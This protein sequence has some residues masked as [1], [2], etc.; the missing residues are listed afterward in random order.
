M[1]TTFKKLL[2]LLPS[3][4]NGKLIILFFMMLFGA[5]LELL[6]IGMIP[7]FV[8]IIA[9]PETILEI[10]RLV[11]AWEALDIEDGGD[12][13]VYGSILLIGVFLL[14]NVY[15]ASFKYIQTRFIWRRFA[16]IGTYLFNQYMRAPYKFHLKRNSSELLRNITQETRLIISRLLTPLLKLVMDAVLILGIF[17]ML[18]WVEPIIT[19]G[20]IVLLGGSSALFLK[21]IKEKTRQY[22]KMAQ[23]DRELMIRSVNEG[24]GGFK[25]ARVLKREGWFIRR[26]Q[27]HINS[28][29]KSQTFQNAASLCTKPVIE[30]IA[31]SGMLLITLTLYW[32]GRGLETIIPILTLF[33]TAT[34]RLLPAIQESAKA[35]TDLRYYSYAV[36]PIYNDILELKSSKVQVKNIRPRKI[37]KHHNKPLFTFE[38]SIN[39]ENVS[40]TY[41]DTHVQAVQKLSLTIPRGHVVGFVG[42]SGAGKTTVVDLLLGLLTP[43]NGHITVD[44]Q[45][46][47]ANLSAWQRNIGYIPQFIFLADDTIRNNIAFGLPA[48]EIDEEKIQNAVETAQLSELIDSITNGLDTIIGE[49]GTRLSGGQRQRIGI[50]RALYHNPQVLIMDEATSALDNVTERDVIEA[51]ER[52]KGDRTI[53]TIAHR[54]TTIRNSDRLYLMKKG[55]IFQQGSYADLADTSDEF[56]GMALMK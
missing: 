56:R 24:L 20:V 35:L 26:F 18:L 46:I 9:S 54:L 22:G 31:V 41:P 19:L 47:Q 42:A 36:E 11:P 7:V 45:D 4:D 25:D 15:L 6:G 34:M 50:A 8:S 27:H 23:D 49:R 33:G 52:L 16:T 2:T 10:D 28:Y 1:L 3:G 14:K 29:A 38:D 39:F 48:E 13:L 43:G 37:K 44:G 55:K 5:L 40:Y 30:S 53:I 21:L 17:A 32:Q 12:L 51:I